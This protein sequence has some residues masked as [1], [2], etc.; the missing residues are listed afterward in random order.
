MVTQKVHVWDGLGLV[1]KDQVVWC[2]A[3]RLEVLH[4]DFNILVSCCIE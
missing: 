3:Y 4:T 2:A 1:I